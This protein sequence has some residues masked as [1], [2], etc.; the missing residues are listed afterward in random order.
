MPIKPMDWWDD[1]RNRL[2]HGLPISVA[3]CQELYYVATSERVD[4]KPKRGPDD[5][6]PS[7]DGLRDQIRGAY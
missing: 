4:D 3:D 1:I 6:L 5:E 7:D 2:Y